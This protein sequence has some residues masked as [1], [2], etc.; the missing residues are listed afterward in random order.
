MFLPKTIYHPLPLIQVKVNGG[1]SVNFIIDTGG[2]EIY[3]DTDFAAKVGATQFGSTIGTYGGGLLA[4][5][6]NGFTPLLQFSE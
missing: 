4:A 2:S 3:L 5:T 1:E 6:A